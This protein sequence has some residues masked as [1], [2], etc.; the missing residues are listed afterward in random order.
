MLPKKHST[1][2][3]TGYCPSDGGKYNNRFLSRAQCGLLGIMGD[4]DVPHHD[5]NVVTFL[6]GLQ[7]V[8]P[9]HGSLSWPGR[10]HLV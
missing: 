1:L 4:W 6:E 8:A 2:E 9:D 3:N 7:I 5:E 10:I